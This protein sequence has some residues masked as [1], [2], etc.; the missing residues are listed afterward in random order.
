MALAVRKR[1]FQVKRKGFLKATYSLKCA[2]GS[3]G[4]GFASLVGN[5]DS[6][7]ELNKSPLLKNVAWG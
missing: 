7:T 3:E 6:Q 4:E 1:F 5:I 2:S